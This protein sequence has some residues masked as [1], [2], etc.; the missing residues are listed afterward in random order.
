MVTARRCYLLASAAAIILMCGRLGF[1]DRPATLMLAERVATGLVILLGVVALLALLAGVPVVLL[2]A[3]VEGLDALFRGRKR[4]RE[5]TL[6]PPARAT[7]DDRPGAGRSLMLAM[8]R[9]IRPWASNSQ[10]SLP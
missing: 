8:R 5:A 7:R 2:L 10:F 4:R 6:T 1:T 9:R 3:L